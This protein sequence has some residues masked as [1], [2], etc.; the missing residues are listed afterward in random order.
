MSR[1]TTPPM[2]L[3]LAPSTQRYQWAW[4]EIN[5]R[6][7][8][9]Q[10]IQGTYMTGVVVVLLLGLVPVN[11]DSARP[12]TWRLGVVLLPSSA[13]HARCRFMGAAQRRYHRLAQRVLPI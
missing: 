7:Q 11:G 3:P 4:Q 1:G 12:E 2:S 13:A 6:L 10:I 8:A 9:R 5:A